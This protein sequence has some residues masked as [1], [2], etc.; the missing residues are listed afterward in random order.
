MVG[1]VGIEPTTIGLKGRCSATELPTPD[2]A[3]IARMTFP[4]NTPRIEE[5]IWHDGAR[6]GEYDPAFSGRVF[7]WNLVR[8]DGRL[9][10]MAMSRDAGLDLHPELL[11]AVLAAKGWKKEELELLGGGTRFSDGTVVHKSTHFGRVP[12]EHRDEILRRLG[13]AG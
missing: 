8:K 7:K 5:V 2:R 13:L 6:T 4:G 11:E 10:L 3:K 12:E 9:I 1:R